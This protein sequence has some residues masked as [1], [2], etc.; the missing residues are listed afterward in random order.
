MPVRS[1]NSSVL[2]WADHKKIEEELKNWIN[3]VVREKRGIIKIGYFGSY[4]RGDYGVGSDLD[5]IIILESSS[6]PFEKRGIDW[7]TTKF[8]VPVDLLIYTIDEWKKLEEE[9][10]PFYKKVSREIVW[11]FESDE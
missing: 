6:L 3:N 8:S 2:K 10:S 9:N 1:L 4:A 11:V 7:D 5:L